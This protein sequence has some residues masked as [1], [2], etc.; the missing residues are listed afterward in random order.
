MVLGDG[1]W[2]LGAAAHEIAE[3]TPGVAWVKQD[4]QRE[5]DRARAFH[6]TDAALAVL[7]E[8]FR[9]AEVRPFP[10]TPDGAGGWRHDGRYAG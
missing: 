2:Q 5:P 6:V 10:T 4:G 3:N 1:V 7:R 9:P 8:Y